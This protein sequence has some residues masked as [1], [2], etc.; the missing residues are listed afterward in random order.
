MRK[1]GTARSRSASTQEQVAGVQKKL[2]F[3]LLLVF[4]VPLVII[5]LLGVYAFRL[6]SRVK[7]VEALERVNVVERVYV[8]TRNLPWAISEYSELAAKYPHHQVFVRLGALHFER[9]EPG[10]A[11]QAI[12]LLN[13][14]LDL[15]RD[16]W[17]AHSTLSYIYGR[18]KK[19]REAIQAG[20]AALRDNEFDAQTYNNLAW[21][22][23][24]SPDTSLKD[25]PRAEGMARKAVEYTRCL[26]PD[27]LDT[28]AE[29]YT[30]LERHNEAAQIRR[31]ITEIAGTKVVSKEIVAKELCA[32]RRPASAAATPESPR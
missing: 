10:D 4:S 27:Y 18:Q 20:E 12:A 5:L 3:R 9:G 30:G 31:A 28:L 21:I 25:L 32:R 29:I 7:E 23:A 26:N 16:Y 19:E 22:Y 11:A 17:E 24:T 6:S 8:T 2:A 15:K 14:A 13:Q 1:T